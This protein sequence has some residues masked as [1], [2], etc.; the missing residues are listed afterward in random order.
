MTAAGTQ[1]GVKPS[2]R[3][4]QQTLVQADNWRKRAEDMRRLAED[5]RDPEVKAM[6]L[7]I[8]ESY[9]LEAKRAEKRQR[10]PPITD[11]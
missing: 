9:E 1:S 4:S 6:M 7:R 2:R 11:A 10:I 5:L 3:R 8:A